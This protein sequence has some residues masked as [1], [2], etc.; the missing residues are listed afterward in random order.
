MERERKKVKFY[1]VFSTLLSM[2]TSNKMFLSA[3]VSTVDQE[4]F[5]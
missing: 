5:V 3:Y 4:I 1:G 2:E